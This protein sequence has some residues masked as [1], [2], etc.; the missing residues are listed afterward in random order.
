MVR[1]T[2]AYVIAWERLG[3]TTIVSPADCL[4]ARAFPVAPEDGKA[5]TEQTLLT[6][7]AARRTAIRMMN[8][9][10]GCGSGDYK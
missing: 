9:S 3:L 7:R 2:D 4:A 8:V 5:K 10:T 6:H 1:S